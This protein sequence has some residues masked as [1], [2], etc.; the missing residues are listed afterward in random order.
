M[1]F[2]VL[3]SSVTQT[4]PYHNTPATAA[5]L[6]TVCQLSQTAVVLIWN[7]NPPAAL[8]QL[9]TAF[10]VLLNKERQRFYSPFYTIN[11]SARTRDM[12]RHSHVHRFL[13]I[14]LS[15][16][17]SLIY[18]LFAFILVEGLFSLIYLLFALILVEGLFSLIYLLFALILVEGLFSLTYLL[19]AYKL[20][21]I[22]IKEWPIVFV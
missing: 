7:C 22:L 12:P 8:L 15:G 19:F 10:S 6:A 5:V 11:L 9:F 3:C 18:L 4:C 1:A 14:L 2:L 16:T 13:N 21:N 20:F 17:F